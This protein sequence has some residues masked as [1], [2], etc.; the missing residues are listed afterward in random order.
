MPQEQKVYDYLR[1]SS[2][3]A[4]EGIQPAMEQGQPKW[5]NSPLCHNQYKFSYAL[6]PP[7]GNLDVPYPF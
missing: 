1:Y 4:R 6:F 7:V 3:W 2:I 5:N